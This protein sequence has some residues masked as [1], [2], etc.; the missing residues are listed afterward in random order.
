MFYLLQQDF[1]LFS[2]SHNPRVMGRTRSGGPRH[3]ADRA[4]GEIRTHGFEVSPSYAKIP[5]RFFL[6]G[7]LSKRA[8]GIEGRTPSPKF[9]ELNKINT[10][11]G[12]GGT[13]FSRSR[14]RSLKENFAFSSSFHKFLVYSLNFHSFKTSLTKELPCAMP[15]L[16]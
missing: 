12:G 14:R 13:L 1:I 7:F 10:L 5:S 3:C 4:E 11:K 16:H 2:K 8:M 9:S 6:R 15:Y